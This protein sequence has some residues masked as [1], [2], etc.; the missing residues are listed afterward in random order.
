[1]LFREH[2]EG[3]TIRYEFEPGD[4]TKYIFLLV[5]GFY[6]GIDTTNQG[7]FALL[8]VERYQGGWDYIKD[9][10]G[11]DSKQTAIILKWFYY[12]YIYGHEPVIP[13]AYF[14]EAQARILHKELVGRDCMGLI[15]HPAI[16]ED[17]DADNT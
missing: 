2:R 17:E 5:P 9:K 10:L 4:G 15:Y 3:P 16:K 14:E 12:H 1:M 6:F 11:L 8:P 7:Q 13:I